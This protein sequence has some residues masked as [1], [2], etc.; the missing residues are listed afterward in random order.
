M[1]WGL[2]P[3]ALM[4]M[5]EVKEWHNMSRLKKRLTGEVKAE[6]SYALKPPNAV[7]V[8]ADLARYQ[9]FVAEW[10]AFEAKF[11][12]RDIQV[13][14]ETKSFQQ[15]KNQHMPVRLI[16][17]TIPALASL[18]G[19]EQLLQDWQHKIVTFMSNSLYEPYRDA[20]KHIML[21]HIDRIDTLSLEDIRLL[22]LVIPQLKKGLGNGL[23]LRGL[24]LAEVGTKFVEQHSFIIE[25]LLRVIYPEAFSIPGSLLGW[26]GCVPHPKDWLVV[27]PLCEDTQAA[28]GGLSLMR[29]TSHTLKSYD[30]PADNILIIENDQSCY[31]LPKVPNTIA[32]SGGGKNV[33]W[34]FESRL[35]NK[36]LAYWGDIDADGFF[37][38][39]EVRKYA[40]AIT[41]IM[42]DRAVLE[43]YQSQMV[44]ENHTLALK[45]LTLLTEQEYELYK[46]LNTG[47]FSGNRLE[48]EKIPLQ[49]VQTQLQQWICET[50]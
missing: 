38:L 50:Q 13:L 47:L 14:W 16:I 20:I 48:Q 2:L 33:S 1:S 40:P 41:S 21:Q 7:Q 42:M 37:I 19:K 22:S 17:T 35:L 43:L 15:L 8:L 3:Q 29:L 25:A 4:Q 46:S 34:L 6:V 10:Q 18:L 5:L 36:K 30:F 44:M 45:E 26:L 39:N 23:Y 28:M 24:P 49:Y 31:S 27:K 32:I 11:A 12:T 9:H